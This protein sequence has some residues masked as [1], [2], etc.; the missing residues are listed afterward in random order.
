MRNVNQALLGKGNHTP[1][2]AAM[3]KANAP[4]MR[5]GAICG[6]TSLMSAHLGHHSKKSLQPDD[7]V[8]RRL[9]RK[10]SDMACT[11][12]SRYGYKLDGN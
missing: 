8:V 12:E 9:V 10:L 1:I 6:T 3:A 11:P 2:A 5:F 7:Y 4:A